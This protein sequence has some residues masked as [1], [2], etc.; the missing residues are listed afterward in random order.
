MESKK[1]LTDK[2]REECR[3][4]VP[5]SLK[6][7]E[8]L[9]KLPYR[10]RKFERKRALHWGQRKLLMSE[11]L[12]LT[13]YGHLSNTILYAGAADGF[14]IPFL[15]RLFP[16][17]KF[18]LYDPAKFHPS[19]SQSEEKIELHNEF[20]TDAVAKKYSSAS[21]IFI[22]D[23]RVAPE[24]FHD[25]AFHENRDVKVQEEME[26][27]V[28]KNMADQMRWHLILNPAVSMLKFRLPYEPGTTT[29]LAGEIHMQVW[30]PPTS[31]ETRLITQTKE[32]ITYDNTDY[33]SRLYR[34]NI[35]TREHQKFDIGIEAELFKHI[36]NNYDLKGEIEIWSEY[37]TRVRGKTNEELPRFIRGLFV[38]LD[39]FFG[40]TLI[41][42][43]Q[44]AEAKTMSRM[45]RTPEKRDRKPYPQTSNEN[46]RP[47]LRAKH[48]IPDELTIVE[49]SGP[50][51]V[52]T[53]E[54][55][56][57]KKFAMKIPRKN[58]GFSS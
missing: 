46:A 47:P 35:C 32:T 42:K 28:K 18:I 10:S 39:K 51:T 48:E 56:N 20:F 29:Y 12:L 49:P 38:T 26:D 55:M 45:Q 41:D 37:L 57:L 11:V 19:L 14:H 34:W 7:S 6:L 15:A 5:F 21:V 3:N 33:E 1:N 9:R 44:E 4:N 52:P 30:A 50:L 43:Y 22:S 40:R 16:Q 24:E 27:D 8:N 31:T 54:K 36:P 58:F 13:K 25:P 53:P 17:H 2:E 23:I